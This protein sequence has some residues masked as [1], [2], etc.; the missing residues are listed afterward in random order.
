M[1]FQ[2][3]AIITEGAKIGPLCYYNIL[4]LFSA[5][6]YYALQLKTY[7]RNYLRSS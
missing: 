3:S 6:Q 2:E 7:G 5:L 1:I 4:R